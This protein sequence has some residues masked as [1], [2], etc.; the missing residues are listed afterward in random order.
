MPNQLRPT[1]PPYYPD[2]TTEWS[3]RSTALSA[4][5]PALE[6]D[7][8][9]AEFQPLVQRL[10]R[11]YGTTPELREDL[12]GEIYFRFCE[13]LAAYDPGRGIPLRPYL[14]RMLTASVYT[15]SRSGWRS[16]KR[17]VSM[18]RFPAEEPSQ[19]ED[20]SEAW[21]E[22]MLQQEV[23]TALPAAIARLPMRQKRVV[24]GRYYEGRAFEEL[25]E[26]LAI[27]PATVRSLLRHG[28]NNLRSQLSATG[29][30]CE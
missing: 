23:I 14:V 24:I 20:P 30:L 2:E 12:R 1:T 28:I 19:S 3:R 26:E 16:Q 17:E 6:R 9:F 18:E 25:A 22:A 10:V 4:P 15:Y 7:A 11:Q 21:A 27:R 8:L 5:S 13:L 29:L